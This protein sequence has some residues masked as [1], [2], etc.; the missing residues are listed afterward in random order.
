[1]GGPTFSP[2]GTRLC[3]L[4]YTTAPEIS[5][6]TLT[7]YDTGTLRAVNAMELPNPEAGLR[8]EFTLDGRSIV[9][10]SQQLDYYDAMSLEHQG[11]Y[12]HPSGTMFVASGAHIW[13]VFDRQKVSLWDSVTRQPTGVVWNLGPDNRPLAIVGIGLLLWA[14]ALNWHVGRES[15]ARLSAPRS[16]PQP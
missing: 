16:G 13:L 7:V 2:D 12:S 8:A 1:M 3:L 6:P 10:V 14:I 5:L 11:S 4:T 15:R 9:I